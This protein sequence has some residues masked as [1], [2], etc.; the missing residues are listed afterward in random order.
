[1]KTLLTCC[2]FL[3][4]SVML[5]AQPVDK[6]K[7]KKHIPDLKGRDYLLKPQK[8]YPDSYAPFP[9]ILNKYT[10]SS[11]YLDEPEPFPL[12]EAGV[13]GVPVAL[14]DSVIAMA[15]GGG[16]NPLNFAT[17]SDSGK[18]W[19]GYV[20]ITSSDFYTEYMTGLKTNSGRVILI[21]FQ[22]DYNTYT[23]QLMM[24]YSDDLITWYTSTVKD[25]IEYYYSLDL[26]C[27]N[28]DKLWLCYSRYNYEYTDR[29]LYYITS[30]TGGM[31]WS[32]E[33]VLL[34]APYNEWDGTIVSGSSN[35]LLAFYSDESSGSTDIYKIA[36]VDGGNTWTS[37]VPVVNSGASDEYRPK[38]IMQPDNTVWVFY[39]TYNPANLLS[40]YDQTDIQYVTSSDGGYTWGAAERFTY[41]SGT[42]E[43][44][45]VVVLFGKP[46]VSFSSNRWGY[47]PY[48]TSTW[49]G[50]IGKT[51]DSN[52][53]PALLDF[54][55]NQLPGG[56]SIIANAYVDD[57]SGITNVIG[58]VYL[59]YEYLETLQM[60]DDGQH[61]DFEAN[62][63]I[64]GINIGSFNIDDVIWVRNSIWD[65][66]NNN[67]IILGGQFDVIPI[68]NAGDLV[69]SL[70]ET[71]Q[72]AEMGFPLGTSAYW[73]GYDYLFLGGLWV[74]GDNAG[75]TIVM[76]TDYYDEDW[77]K[78]QGSV[79][80]M[81]PGISDQDCG[82]FYDDASTV[83]L[84]LG[85]SVH[86]KSYQWSTQ[87]R[88]DFIIF[89]Y[90]IKNRTY[91][92]IDNFFVSLW[93]DPD[94]S[95]QTLTGD[96][97]GAYDPGRG[98]IYMYDPSGNPSGYLG[99]RLLT[100]MPNTA[101]LY[102]P[103]FEGDPVSD[104]ER[105]LYMISG[106]MPD[107]TTPSD[108]RMLLTSQTFNLAPGDSHTVAFGL[109]MGDGL[110][111]LQANSDTMKALFN[112]YV[113]GV[114]D[115]KINPLPDKFSISQNY[116]NPF[117][118]AA[119]IKYSVP[120]TS[121]VQLKVFDVLGNEIET[122]VN[123]EK[124]AGVYELTW[125]AAGLPSGVYF[126]QIKAGSYVDTKKAILLK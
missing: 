2:L 39:Y 13:F 59:N 58:E 97:L 114:N 113:V 38:V 24:A 69:L 119:R 106:I 5:I 15:Y 121:M 17:S 107:P 54:T 90:L 46:F 122:L 110:S 60:Y 41:Y 36:S 1:M 92:E 99:V 96:D 20:T 7:T 104:G 86:Q 111:E 10:K 79:T 76:N 3:L 34:S 87:G 9:K 50:L 19:G 11:L 8:A 103:N 123:E 18:T 82:I 68:H 124:P 23:H 16:Y 62:D 83:S 14:S 75:G 64:W 72:L 65:I 102:S 4:L 70:H 118:P 44:Q 95:A 115:K 88:D 94:I 85:V 93:L 101:Y 53:P 63:N 40:G 35:E 6:S 25:N 66:S 67:V 112:Q 21:W 109:V 100:E 80:T 71:S 22:I 30:T 33:N 77:F 74:G 45:N 49:Y 28:D 47:Y 117:N 32:D 61:N 57:E 78:T 91:N 81:M 120:Q 43:N 98:M 125:N 89:E 29:D 48:S 52:P 51:A 12:G 55:Y 37:P 126:Y 105:Y 116:P 108:Y 27:T 84:P 73:H 26:S 42:D 31:V 56:S